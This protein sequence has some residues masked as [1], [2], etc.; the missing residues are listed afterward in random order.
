M[1]MLKLDGSQGEGGGQILRSALTLSM[2]TGIPFRIEHIRAGRAKPGL[3]RQHLTAVAASAAICG[4]EVSGNSAGSQTLEFIPHAIRGGDY[5][6]DIGTAG[7]CTLVL[8]TVLPALWF[9]DGPSTVTVR[10][11][12]HNGAAPPADFLVRSWL[13]LMR[14]MGAEMDIELVRHGFYPA[15][16]GE[17]RAAVTPRGPLQPLELGARGEPVAARA[18]AVVAGLPAEIAHRELDHLAGAFGQAEQEMRVLSSREG[19][20]NVVMLEI[21]HG[22]HTEVFTAF[23]EKGLKAEVVAE[24]TA[25]EAR[26]WLTSGAAVGE[27]LADQL[28]LPLALAGGG[29]FTASAFSSHTQTNIGV[30]EKFLPVEFAVA[31]HGALYRVGIGAA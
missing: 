10:G 29:G 28:L 30:I 22:L 17:V 11:G 25:L 26:G 1:D 12:T 18:I 6:F 7:S 23:G 5:R 19:P 9:A 13:P 2:I 27:H 24:R 3:L 31:A 20:G 21:R 4:A 14:R 16:G 8:Q 15:G